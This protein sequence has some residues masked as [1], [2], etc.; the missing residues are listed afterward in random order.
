MQ[1]QDRKPLWLKRFYAC[2]KGASALEFALAAPAFIFFVAGII[3][4]AMIMLVSVLAEGGIREAARFG[5]TGQDPNGMT[6]EERLVE[7]IQE[8]THGLIDVSAENVS[9]KVYGDYTYIGAEEPYVDANANSQYDAGED[10]TDWNDNGEWDSDTGEDGSGGSGDIVLY[11]VTY[12][13]RF[14]TPLFSVFGGEDGALDLNAT[15]AV[16]NEP[17]DVSGG[18]S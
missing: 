1:T 10:Y 13:Y 2:R 15:V 11:E 14:M 16:R 12:T 9:F 5:I 3:E 7:I 4:I 18:A 17:Y 6:R 8:H